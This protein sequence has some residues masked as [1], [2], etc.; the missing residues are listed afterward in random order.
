M[1]D[2]LKFI[3]L[4]GMSRS[5]TKLLRDLLNN[6]TQI[7]IDPLETQFIPKLY[8]EFNQIDL[9]NVENFHRFYLA[10]LESVYAINTQ[11][12]SQWLPTEEEWFDACKTY[13]LT[14]VFQCFYKL[15][16]FHNNPIAT[17]I[18]DKTPR[19][20]GH[21]P[22]LMSLF[23]G[24]KFIHI[25]RD[26]R[27]R[28]LS[29][30]EVWGKS[31][32]K[33]VSDW[34]RVLTHLQSSI[35]S[36]PNSFIEIRYEDFV[37]DPSL[38]LQKITSFLNL[39]WKDDGMTT[40]STS[41][42]QYGEARGSLTTIDSSVGRY[43]IKINDRTACILEQIAFTMLKH[44]GYAVSFASEEKSL[45]LF[46]SKLLALYGYINLCFFHMKDKGLIKGWKYFRRISGRLTRG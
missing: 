3:F 33:S 39:P 30:K 28:A 34:S 24:A 13:T 44:Y 41:P 40:L 8:Q 7:F 21:V 46:G 11:E 31:L 29:E 5:G 32:R 2:S 6:H 35:E 16:S 9:S 27:D 18:G 17:V 1:P 25:V 4:I 36:K 10:F 12:K 37:V 22:L 23:P 15:V 20:T 43:R 26:P 14:D 42:E 19:Y 38:S 45:S